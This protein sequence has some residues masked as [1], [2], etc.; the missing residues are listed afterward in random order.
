MTSTHLNSSA[1]A[2]RLLIRTDVEVRLGFHSNVHPTTLAVAVLNAQEALW[3]ALTHLTHL[4][5]E[6]ESFNN[7]MISNCVKV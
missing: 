2:Q 3:I 4:T 7:S 5:L 6:L 1:S